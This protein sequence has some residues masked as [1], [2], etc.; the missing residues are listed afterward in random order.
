MAELPILTPPKFTVVVGVTV[1]STSA[2]AVATAEH[3][4]SLPPVSTAVIATLY[5][6]PVVS[7]VSRKLTAWLGGGVEVEVAT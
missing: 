2:A 7:P 6:A 1:M 3:P 5:V 4:L